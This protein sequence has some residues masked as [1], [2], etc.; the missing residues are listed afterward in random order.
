MMNNTNSTRLVLVASLVGL[1]WLP[2][3]NPQKGGGSLSSFR[4]NI[5]SFRLSQQAQPIVQTQSSSFNLEANQ[6]QQQTFA[7]STSVNRFEAQQV[8]QLEA[9]AEPAFYG[10]V[11]GSP[12]VDFPA[13]T[14]IPLTKFSC[15][16]QPFEP[17]FYADEETGCQVFHLCFDGRKESFLCGIGTVFNQATLNCDYWHSVECS[18]SSQYYS[19]N[20]ELGKTSAASFSSQ[21]KIESIRSKF[22]SALSIPSISRTEFQRVQLNVEA[23]RPIVSNTNKRVESSFTSSNI[24]AWNREQRFQSSANFAGATKG[25]SIGAQSGTR[26]S[27]AS[28]IRGYQSS[29]SHLDD[30]QLESKIISVNMPQSVAQDFKLVQVNDSFQDDVWRPI[31]KSKNSIAK[32]SKLSSSSKAQSASEPSTTSVSPKPTDRSPSRLAAEAPDFNKTKAS[33][34][35]TEPPTTNSVTTQQTQTTSATIPTS[36]AP[37]SEATTTQSSSAGPDAT[38]SMKLE[39]T[40][41]KTTTTN[42]VTETTKRA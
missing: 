39:V 40:D 12:G 37:K 33:D 13:L 20:S 11:A 3:V 24:G 31:S 9:D 18:K 4:Q 19:S 16:G 5:E 27:P 36:E 14:R 32:S 6:Q 21:K 34:A 8:S 29:A 10:S 17:G 1:L 2:R 30:G 38:V 35:P 42:D 23:P 15:N 25:G 26:I 41:D 7:K 22:T 28:L